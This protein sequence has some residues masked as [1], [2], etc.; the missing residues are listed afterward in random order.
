MAQHI[1]K[2]TIGDFIPL[3]EGYKSFVLVKSKPE[4]YIGDTL[5]IENHVKGVFS[6]MSV[7]KEI[8]FIQSGPDSGLEE[9]YCIMGL[10]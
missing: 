2:L 7:E 3:Y 6:G 8:T 10:R 5:L 9:G 4:L 1:L